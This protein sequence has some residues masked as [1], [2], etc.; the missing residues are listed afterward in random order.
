[1][2]ASKRGIRLAMEHL[3]LDWGGGSPTVTDFD[4]MAAEALASDDLGEG[5]AAFRER[6]AP[7]FEGH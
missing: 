2:R 4:L 5:I 1:M 3:T 6:R 7:N